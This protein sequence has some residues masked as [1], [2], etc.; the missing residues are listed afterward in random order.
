MGGLFELSIASGGGL[1]ATIE[2]QRATTNTGL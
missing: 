1:C 2:L